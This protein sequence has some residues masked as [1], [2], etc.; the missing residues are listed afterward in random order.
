MSNEF[1]TDTK[2]EAGQQKAD[3]GSY[4]R[5]MA[6]GCQC[7]ASVSFG[8]TGLC[9]FHH[10]CE[11][12]LAWQEVTRIIN[13]PEVVEFR[14]ALYV[15]ANYKTMH[16]DTASVDVEAACEDAYNK[17][18][19]IRI[20]EDIA[21]RATLYDWEG[22]PFLELPEVY[23]YRLSQFLVGYVARWAMRKTFGDRYTVRVD[24]EKAKR[25]LDAALAAFA[26]RGRDLIDGREAA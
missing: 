25:H 5:C 11:E 9:S 13:T 1:I 17:A 26:G 24:P 16:R 19:V 10:A 3:T 6:Y 14:Q 15:L 8:T 2:R 20:P 23:G 12:T 21:Q 18:R 7:A 4:M 22:K